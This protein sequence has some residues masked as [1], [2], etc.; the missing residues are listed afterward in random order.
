MDEQAEVIEFLAAGPA[1][2]VPPGRVERITTHASH[3]F[4][5]DGRA[6]KLKRALKYSYLDYSTPALRERFTRAE[7][8]LNR[9]TAP[10]L[11]LRVRAITR[12]EDGGLEFDGAGDAVD[13]VLEMNRFPEENLFDRLAEDGRLTPALARALADGIA[14]FHAR[15]TVLPDHGGR[16]AIAAVIDDNLVNLC[17]VAPPLPAEAVAGVGG[18]MR[19][20][21]VRLGPLLDRRRAAGRV[22]RCHGDLHL[23]N[24]CLLDGGP[25]LFD[26]I[27]F[28]DE[29]ACIDVLHDLAFLLMDLAERR[30]PGLANIVFNR[31]LDRSGD[32]AGLPALPL[33]QAMRA[34]VRAEVL[35]VRARER[36]DGDE[37][38]RAADYLD[39]AGRL[40]APARPRLIGM[41]GFSGTGKST[42]A[43][44]VAPAF[45]P[46]PGARVIRSDVIRKR[47]MG[48]APEVRL[49]PIAYEEA[50]SRA[51]YAAMMSEARATLAAGYTAILDATFMDA[52]DRAAAARAAA[53][54]N[55]PFAGLW[56]EAPADLLEARVAGRHDDASDADLAVL[57]NQLA[58]NIA[59]LDWRRIDASGD[60]D[61]A[62]AAARASL[63]A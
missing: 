58:V 59:G 10:G 34:A 18:G 61:S 14:G 24:V 12:A 27:E 16:A 5:A 57:R 29:F 52:Q 46:A 17:A 35:G 23:G 50:I 44:T 39:L 41:G 54:A 63:A 62:A 48:V 55:V 31:Y 60:S 28:N 53:E 15:A 49:P 42:V 13:W 2:G 33:F 47:L 40:L 26:C 11:Y 7:L 4:L 1:L 6:W 43:M 25:T 8:N 30:L 9:R 19:A 20:A 22:R 36:P 45:G 3:L 21:L 37:G 51:V 38:A 56:L 32:V